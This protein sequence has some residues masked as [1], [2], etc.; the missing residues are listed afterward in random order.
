MI[1]KMQWHLKLIATGTMG[2]N[3]LPA[4]GTFMCPYKIEKSMYFTRF[5]LTPNIKNNYK[6]TQN[7]IGE[8]LGW[9]RVVIK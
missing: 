6:F 7:Y 4:K 2:I 3:L 9:E 5:I 8:K 1:S